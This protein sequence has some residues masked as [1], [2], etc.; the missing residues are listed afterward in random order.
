M[1]NEFR[2]VEL[3]VGDVRGDAC[4][5]KIGVTCP[6]LCH[7]QPWSARACRASDPPTIKY[8]ERL[9]EAGIE[10]SVVSVGVS[11]DNALAETINGLQKAHVISPA[12]HFN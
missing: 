6:S 11:Y 2:E 5:S 4:A 10:P 9:A 7:S 12:S 8:P 3:M 1:S